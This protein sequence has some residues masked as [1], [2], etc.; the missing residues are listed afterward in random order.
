VP[1]K[2]L[3]QQQRLRQLWTRGISRSAT[4]DHNGV[5]GI[6]T[7]AASVGSAGFAGVLALLLRLNG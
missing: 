3:A 5:S 4:S 2:R 1:T 7:R 6:L